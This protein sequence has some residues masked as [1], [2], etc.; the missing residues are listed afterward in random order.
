MGLC[1]KV[2]YYNYSCKRKGSEIMNKIHIH[3]IVILLTAILI[4]SS[5]PAPKLTKN[6]V[7]ITTDKH[8]TVKYESVLVMYNTY[9]TDEGSGD[10][11][12]DFITEYVKTTRKQIIVWDSD[13]YLDTSQF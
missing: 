10:R 3:S 12:Y 5:A 4:T 8:Q 2:W 1:R 11:Y 7:Y 9:K 13:E 6:D